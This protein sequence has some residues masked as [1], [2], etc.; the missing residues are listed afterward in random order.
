MRRSL[1]RRID[2][3]PHELTID[4][5]FMEG[6][7]RRIDRNSTDPKRGKGKP[8]KYNP[9]VL[10]KDLQQC[11]S[12]RNTRKM[13]PSGARGG[14]VVEMGALDRCGDIARRRPTACRLPRGTKPEP[15]IERK[16]GF[17][18]LQSVWVLDYLTVRISHVS[19]R[20]QSAG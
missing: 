10:D 12:G 11:T 3:G 19:S 9:G 2:V 6:G 5:L 4:W 20:A 7:K 8:L 14:R 16:P 15:S 13:A 17:V 1:V 18:T